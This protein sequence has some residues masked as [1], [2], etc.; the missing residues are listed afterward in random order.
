[1][2]TPSTDLTDL[3]F[4]HPELTK[5]TGKPDTTSV[6]LLRREVF[7]NAR[8]VPALQGG[9]AHRHL[10][11]V[12]PAADYLALAGVAWVAPV[13]WMPVSWLTQRAHNLSVVIRYITTVHQ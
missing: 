1:M 10:G 3:T 8:A 2:T 12:M 11:S 4:E 7:A 13:H 5:I 6:N 9:G